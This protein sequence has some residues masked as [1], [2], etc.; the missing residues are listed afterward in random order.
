MHV[1]SFQ[2]HRDVVELMLDNGVEVNVEDGVDSS[3][4]K[5]NEGN[6]ERGRS[7]EQQQ[8]VG[9][10][11]DGTMSQQSLDAMGSL[12]RGLGPMGTLQSSPAA[13]SSSSEFSG[14]Q[15]NKTSL[16]ELRASPV[17]SMAPMHVQNAHEIPEYEI[18]PKELDFSNSVDIA[19]FGTG[20]VWFR[21]QI[22]HNQ[23][24][25]GS[26]LVSTVHGSVRTRRFEPN[27]G[28]P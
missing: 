19:K 26:G 6:G 9:Q 15:K 8:V 3:G 4:K 28:H 17:E 2:G 27:C 22:S 16:Q 7:K 11:L 24:P 1:A 23:K 25:L 5:S 13:T 12:K 20:T 21:F 14:S 18:D 10:H